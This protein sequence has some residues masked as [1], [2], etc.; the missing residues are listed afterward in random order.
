M[1][2]AIIGDLAGSIYEYDQIKK[3]NNITI[4]NIIEDNAFYSDDTILTLAIMDAIVTKSSYEDK[5]KE[6]ANKYID[7]IPNHKPYFKTTFSPGFTKWAKSDVIGTSAGNGAMMRVSPVGYLFNTEKEVIENAR[8]A[9]IPS[10]NSKEAIEAATL[11][12][13]I[14]FYARNNYSKEEIIDKLNITI[15]EP[16]ITT[17]NYTC[18]DTID[19][20]MYSLFNSNSFENAIKLAISFGGDTDT[21]ACIVG[22]M[23]EAM[24]GIDKGLKDKAMSKLPKEMTNIINKV[25]KEK[26]RVK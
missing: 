24:Y 6:W 21:N 25:Y 10:H 15:K 17:F 19:V 22:S 7:Y 16:N 12:A 9:T 8:L 18:M 14:I 1:L 23:A 20:C 3:V 11:V 2:G 5:L 13:L 26:R 4:N